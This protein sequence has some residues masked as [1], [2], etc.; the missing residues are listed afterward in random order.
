MSVRRDR[1]EKETESRNC[2]MLSSTLGMP[3]ASPPSHPIT[4]SCFTLSP[5]HPPYLPLPCLPFTEIHLLVR[6]QAASS[7]TRQSSIDRTTP[8]LDATA[9]TSR[10]YLMHHTATQHMHNAWVEIHTRTNKRSE[11]VFTRLYLTPHTSGCFSQGFVSYIDT[12][13]I[14]RHRHTL[15]RMGS[16]AKT[17]SSRLTLWYGRLEQNMEG[18]VEEE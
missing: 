9:S 16:L 14:R 11:H 10:I 5:S 13:A 17:V 2:L 3:C 18:G 12:S 6:S 4:C 8:L 15:G 7:A 1:G